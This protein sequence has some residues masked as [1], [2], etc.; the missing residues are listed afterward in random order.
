MLSAPHEFVGIGIRYDAGTV[1]F[2]SHGSIAQDDSITGATQFA[3]LAGGG[4]AE[5]EIDWTRYNRGAGDARSGFTFD[6]AGS[7]TA[8]ASQSGTRF[9]SEEGRD[10][11]TF[12]GR[13][14][15]GNVRDFA[16]FMQPDESIS[17][18]NAFQ[19][20][21]NHP[22]D[23]Q[24]MRLN[25]MG[26]VETFTLT[27]APTLPNGMPPAS[28]LTLT[29]MFRSGAVS[30]TRHVVG[31]SDGIATLDGGERLILGTAHDVLLTDFD[32]ADGI[33]GVAAGRL[34]AR[35]PQTPGLYQNGVYRGAVMVTGP[36]S[37]AFFG[38]D[39]TSLGPDGTAVANV[40]IRLQF[41]SFA[42]GG[43]TFQ[44]YRQDD[45]DAGMRTTVN[46][47]TWQTI[48][49]PGDMLGPSL[50]RIQLSDQAGS[51][52]FLFFSEGSLGASRSL[53]FDEI[54][55]PLDGYEELFGAASGSDPS[56]GSP[57]QPIVIEF[58]A[59]NQGGCPTIYVH[60]R[61]ESGGS[62]IESVDLIDQ[63]GGELVV[64]E[65]VSWISGARHFWAG[66]SASGEV[67][68]WHYFGDVGF[69]YSNL[70]DALPGATRILGS[71]AHTTYAT[72]DTLTAAWQ[73]QYL[74]GVDVNGHFVVYQQIASALDVPTEMWRFT[75]A[76]QLGL[77]DA[78]ALP[79]FTSDLVGW[80]SSWG[81]VHFAGLDADGDIW[82]VWMIPSMNEWFV[83][84]T[85]VSESTQAAPVPLVGNLSVVRTPWETFHIQGTDASGN[86]IS[87]WWAPGFDHW[88]VENLTD[89]FD[90]PALVPGSL[91][92]N[93]SLGLQN[94]N[95]VGADDDG[96]A[97][98][99]WW[100]AR[101]GWNV[102]SLSRAV[103]LGDIPLMPWRF[104]S[105]TWGTDFT[106]P[107]VFE[108]SQSLLGH[109]PDGHLVRLV[110]RTDMTDA[111]L[112]QDITADSVPFFL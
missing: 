37:A 112:V 20:A 68:V 57:D 19:L 61:L 104:T 106:G 56:L 108:H 81:A 100:N 90:G 47:G 80:G 70:T 48:Q 60:E 14:M 15:D 105:T 45:Y 8:Y 46:T 62:R 63:A 26:E 31:F 4:G 109:H 3:T 98:I 5:Q 110:W 17:T 33:V 59:A 82:S 21:L 10:I 42:G 11:G 54:R 32:N 103:D 12:V 107:P 22:I 49:T 41:V 77:H 43:N 69:L 6:T 99:Y 27:I 1:L 66:L 85:N 44:V 87:T 75:N 24:M 16:V 78:G 38:V 39:P 64:G 23:L 101:S 40:V 34:R 72:E 91:T 111:W 102:N 95:I 83:S 18:F 94:I 67:Q 35:I 7:F 29:Y 88:H 84:V 53:E 86:L 28:D 97:R 74:A 89:Q 2:F 76:S 92:S 73:D 93:F 9:I 71:L 36:D 96:Q 52:A 13:D 58:L 79:V 51:T 55:T 50:Y 30:A 25:D 65:L